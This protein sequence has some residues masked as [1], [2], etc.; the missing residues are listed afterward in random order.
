M[1][2]VYAVAG[3]KGGVGKTTTSINLGT[4]LA[5]LDQRVVT[6]ELD[7]AMANLVDFIDFDVDFETATTLHDVLAGR[8]E[9]EAATYE[10]DGGLTA[11]PSGTDLDR[12]ADTDLERLPAIIEQLRWEYDVV[13]LDTPAGLSEETI[14]PMQLSDL[15]IIVSTPRISSVRNAQN[16][17]QLARRT[18]TDVFGLVLSKSGTGASPGATRIAEFL[19]V[20][21]LGHVPEDEAVPHAQD[22]GEPVVRNAPRSGAAIAYHKIARKLGA[23]D[24]VETKR[25]ATTDTELH[26]VAIDE[27]DDGTA[28]TT[29]GTQSTS[30]D[31]RRMDH[32]RPET[33]ADPLTETT[34]RVSTRGGSGT[35]GLAVPDDEQKADADRTADG[36]GGQAADDGY[37]SD[38]AGQRSL[39]DRFRSLVGL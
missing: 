10:T 11:V 13:L 2:E 16:T 36:E 27:T 22:R 29:E 26:Q 6:V 35:G 5:D 7:L 25:A 17:I 30:D 8:A 19:D 37:D 18:E 3:A 31:R 39:A 32:T 4:V 15:A 20:D 34:D 14:R 1:T 28:I 21:L 24:E 38:A 12:Y 23:T 33:T 9:L